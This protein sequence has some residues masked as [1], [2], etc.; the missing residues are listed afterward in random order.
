MSWNES[1][2]WRCWE[3]TTLAGVLNGPDDLLVRIALYDTQTRVY[4]SEFRWPALERL[5]PND[6]GGRYAQVT[7]RFGDVRWSFETA[8]DGARTYV[9]VRCLDPELAGNIQIRLETLYLRDNGGQ[10]VT[11]EEE[12]VARLAGRVWRVTSPSPVAYRSG[13][14]I[15]AP[16]TRPFVAVIEPADEAGRR[17]EQRTEGARRPAGEGRAR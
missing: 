11:R 10:I 4:Q 15:T 2:P 9:L 12:V 7:L 8:A 6:Y 3:R 16:L 14:T 17:L 1:N 13:S 5:G